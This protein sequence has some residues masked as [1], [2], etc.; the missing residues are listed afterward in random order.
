M[1]LIGHTAPW[2]ELRDYTGPR[3][4]FTARPS[5]LAKSREDDPAME[6]W[7]EVIR[8][9]VILAPRLSYYFGFRLSFGD[10]QAT[11]HYLDRPLT[12]EFIAPRMGPEKLI[13]VIMPVDPTAP[14][15]IRAEQVM[16][17]RIDDYRFPRLIVP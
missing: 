13:G 2:C 15:E 3:A 7:V 11:I 10:D 5:H 8:T 17:L 12:E 16:V 4:E 9:R 6:S 1:K 14:V